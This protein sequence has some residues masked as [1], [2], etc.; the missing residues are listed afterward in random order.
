MVLDF[1]SFYFL[2]QSIESLCTITFYERGWCS[3]RRGS[4]VIENP[5]FLA[6]L[7]NATSLEEKHIQPQSIFTVVGSYDPTILLQSPKATGT[8]QVS[9]QASEWSTTI[10]VSLV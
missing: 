3:N 4:L 10:S 2:Q 8:Y 9:F 1:F 5:T 6:Y 7:E